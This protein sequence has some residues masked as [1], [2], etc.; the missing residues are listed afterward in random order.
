MDKA[1]VVDALKATTFK[2]VLGPIT[3]DAKGD[4]K[5]PTYV[6]YVWRNGKFDYL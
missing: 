2:T 5:E 3:F 4:V 6:V 1:R